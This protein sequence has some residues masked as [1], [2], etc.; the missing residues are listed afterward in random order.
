MTNPD[1]LQFTKIAPME[2]TQDGR[3]PSIRGSTPSRPTRSSRPSYCSSSVPSIRSTVPGASTARLV[4]A[5][6]AILSGWKAG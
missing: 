5:G 1:D 4:K 2:L 3:V 6:I